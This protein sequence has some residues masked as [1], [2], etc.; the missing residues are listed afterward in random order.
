MSGRAVLGSLGKGMVMGA[1]LLCLLPPLLGVALL[2][3]LA[4][5]AVGVASGL[6]FITMTV[7]VVLTA[8]AIFGRNGARAILRKLR[9]SP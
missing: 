4:A 6:M 1:A 9:G 2:H 3:G 7:L 8:A 5:L